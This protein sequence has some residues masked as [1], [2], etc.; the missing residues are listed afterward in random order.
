MHEIKYEY[1]NEWTISKSAI[2]EDSSITNNP[3]DY[4]F[5]YVLEEKW[6]SFNYSVNKFAEAYTN[7]LL[8]MPESESKKDCHRLGPLFLE[9]LRTSTEIFDVL[10]KKADIL[11][12]RNTQTLSQEDRISLNKIKKHLRDKSAVLNNKIK[13]ENRKIATQTVV[14]KKHN[15]ERY[16]C[17]LV[18][19]ISRLS[20]IS[21]KEFHNDK[22]S[23][24]SYVKWIDEIIANLYEADEIFSK[25]LQRY[26]STKQNLI[27]V[28][29]I[30]KDFFWMFNS[31]PKLISDGET[32]TGK[33]MQDFGSYTKI[34][35][36]TYVRPPEGMEINFFMGKTRK[37]EIVSFT[38][39]TRK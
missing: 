25:I 35:H 4:D 13:H 30:K 16:F 6:E 15:R 21:D 11:I 3:F 27:E 20:K 14:R 8:G 23:A 34:L 36:T 19:I 5:P 12:K 18:L 38:G 26:P 39:V 37:N 2:E 7:L 33:S 28:R 9:T 17:F 29:M 22:V 24:F 10:K 1:K 31:F 32:Y